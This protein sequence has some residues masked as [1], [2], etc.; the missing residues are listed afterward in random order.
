MEY[1]RSHGSFDDLPLDRILSDF[2]EFYPGFL[3][4]ARPDDPSFAG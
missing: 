2:D 3:E 4:G 1:L